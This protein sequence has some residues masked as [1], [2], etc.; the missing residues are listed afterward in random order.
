MHIF[1]TEETE[2]RRAEELATMQPPFL[3]PPKPEKSELKPT[4]DDEI[5]VP[6]V[7]T[8]SNSSYVCLDISKFA[9][10]CF[11]SFLKNQIE[12]RNKQI[13]L[14]TTYLSLIITRIWIL[15]S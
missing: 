14:A 13:T 11:E 2:G 15:H 1:E 4:T 12:N 10:I 6:K 8:W 9:N 7:T 3:A 5:E